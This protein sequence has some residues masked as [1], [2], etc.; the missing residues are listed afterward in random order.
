MLHSSLQYSTRPAP[1]SRHPK[2]TSIAL[3]EPNLYTAY[4][5]Y[6]REKA[7]KTAH[8]PK[9]KENR[10]RK[11]MQVEDFPNFAVKFKNAMKDS[12]FG[13]IESSQQSSRADIAL[14]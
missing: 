9:G 6:K 11:S 10:K 14:Y 3:M 13:T 4:A 12:Q 8:K 2:P 7:K 5:D 1:S